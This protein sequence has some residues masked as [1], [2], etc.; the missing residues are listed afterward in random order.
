MK[1]E[2]DEVMVK[3]FTHMRLSYP[4]QRNANVLESDVLQAIKMSLPSELAKI[5]STVEVPKILG[6]RSDRTAWL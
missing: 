3:E 2:K 6:K 4:I 1:D 5:S